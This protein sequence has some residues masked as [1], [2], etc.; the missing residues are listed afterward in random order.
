MMISFNR[1]QKP[2]I[3]NR[4]SNRNSEFGVQPKGRKYFFLC[5][6]F[7]DFRNAKFKNKKS[8]ILK[9]FFTIFVFLFSNN[10]HSLFTNK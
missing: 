9:T 2:T 4:N 1:K 5:V 8:G 6:H 3:K 10:F 7:S